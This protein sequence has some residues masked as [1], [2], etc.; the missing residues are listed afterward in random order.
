MAHGHGHG[1]QVDADRRYLWLSLSL[2]LGFM[3]V[4][5][6]I[7]LLAGSLALLA[8][9]GHMVSDAAAIGLALLAMRLAARPA[10]G[11][12]TFGLKRAEIL[13]A[14]VN[15]L[16]LLVM[17]VYFVIEGIKR[18]IDPPAVSGGLVLTVAL[19]GI[20][21]NFAATLLLSRANRQSLNIEGTYQ[22][23]LTDLYAFAGTAVA[24][25]VVLTTGW[26]RAD[27]VATLF[28]AL[29]MGFAAYKL[30]RESARVL[31]EAAPRGLDPVVIKAELAAVPG[32]TDIHDLHIWE[33]TSNFPAVAAH[34]I[35]E[36]DFDCH[37]RRGHLEG[38]LA[39]AY[40]IRH[41]TLQV[42][43]RD[44]VCHSGEVSDAG[45]HDDHGCP[46]I[47]VPRKPSES[48]AHAAHQH[49]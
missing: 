48:S 6:V 13:S 35:I 49:R 16:T 32:V 47:A 43:H 3:A 12:Y 20:V 2:I 44:S 22:H 19:A 40:G 24:G 21:V 28:V 25:L 38:L 11:A 30:V 45:H 1:V 9:A 33:V 23:I 31:L 41:S 27:A 46:S 14:M 5:V 8:D 4:E 17:T 18:L 15:G 29:L 39:G 7:G 37:E 26:N 42:D 10:F 34:V 36:P